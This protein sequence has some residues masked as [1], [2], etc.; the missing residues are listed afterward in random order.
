M[1]GDIGGVK[2]ERR[3]RC[4]EIWEETEVLWNNNSEIWEETE[5]VLNNNNEILEETEVL[6]NV[7]GDSGGVK[8]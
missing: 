6:C 2:Y 8:Q 4:C 1:R 3:Q 5:V 7:R